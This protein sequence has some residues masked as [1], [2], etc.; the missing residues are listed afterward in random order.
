VSRPRADSLTIAN[1]AFVVAMALHVFD[2]TRQARGLD[3]LTREVIAGGAV[4][5][6]LALTTLVLTLRHSQYA[7]FAA[8]LVGFWTAIAVAASHLAPHWSA[9]SDPYAGL[10]L[11]FF[12]WAVV[13]AEIATA[14]LLGIAGLVELRRR[15]RGPTAA[16]L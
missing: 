12:S 6:L 16:R 13:I 10:G 15:Q 8:T 9:F 5:G 4:L 2:H 11:G 3:A 14:A 7:P 1:L